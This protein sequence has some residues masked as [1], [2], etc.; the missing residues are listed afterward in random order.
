MNHHLLIPCFFSLCISGNA[1]EAVFLFDSDIRRS[2]QPRESVVQPLSV[3]ARSVGDM[4]KEKRR[5]RS[6]FERIR[7]L[8]TSSDPKPTPKPA[9]KVRSR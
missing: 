8:F 5:R 3:F 6:W 4:D 2:A 9:D 1:D 7:R